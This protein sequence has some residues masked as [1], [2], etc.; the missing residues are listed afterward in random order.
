[1]GV[2]KYSLP[3]STPANFS[4]LSLDYDFAKSTLPEHIFTQFLT[5]TIKIS[6]REIFF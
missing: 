3:I 4:A 5:F 2:S 1:M 6:I